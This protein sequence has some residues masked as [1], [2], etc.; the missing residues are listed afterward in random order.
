MKWDNLLGKQTAL[1]HCSRDLCSM[2]ELAFEIDPNQLA[3]QENVYNISVIN[4]LLLGGSKRARVYLVTLQAA[5]SSCPVWT[6]PFRVC[7][8]GG[9]T[10]SAGFF[11]EAFLINCKMCKAPFSW[12]WQRSYSWKALVQAPVLKPVAPCLGGVNLRVSAWCHAASISLLGYC[13]SSVCYSVPVV[14]SCA[15]GCGFSWVRLHVFAPLCTSDV[16]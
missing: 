2:T 12:E 9:A 15:L 7:A 3:W 10:D 16:V 14:R 4:L 11:F 8:G 1:H 5:P 13:F 6:D